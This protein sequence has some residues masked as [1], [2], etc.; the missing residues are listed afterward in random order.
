MLVISWWMFLICFEH[1]ERVL[2]FALCPS[3]PPWPRKASSSAGGIWNSLAGAGSLSAA[4]ESLLCFGMVVYGCGNHPDITNHWAVSLMRCESLELGSTCF[5]PTDGSGRLPQSPWVIEG[6]RKGDGSVEAQGRRALFFCGE[7]VYGFEA[8]AP[9]GDWHQFCYIILAVAGH[10]THFKSYQSENIRNRESRRGFVFRPHDN[11]SHFHRLGGH[12]YTGGSALW[13]RGDDR[14][15]KAWKTPAIFI[16]CKCCYC[17]VSKLQTC[18]RHG[19]MKQMI[20]RIL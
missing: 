6:E 10:E 3:E 7:P 13:S 8:V 11:W 16:G 17:T 5:G 20:L 9:L 2:P 4:C 14:A 12:R 19:Q 15:K 1:F 18:W